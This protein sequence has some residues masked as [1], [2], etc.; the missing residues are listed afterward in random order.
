MRETCH[1]LLFALKFL[2]EF[3]Y[4]SNKQPFSISNFKCSQLHKQRKAD[5]KVAIN[6]NEANYFALVLV[7]I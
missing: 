3:M 1:L 4:E 5:A 7:V 2:A 6:I